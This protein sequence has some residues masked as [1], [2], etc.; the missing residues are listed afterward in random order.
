MTMDRQEHR[1]IL[2]PGYA[3]GVTEAMIEDLV[4]AFYAKVRADAVL[5]PIF[6]G[7][8]GDHWDEHLSKLCDFWSS[9]LLASGRYSGAPMQVHAAL[10]QIQAEHFGQ[11]L[12]LFKTTAAELWPKPAAE[13]VCARA[14]MIAKSF[15]YGIAASRGDLIDSRRQAR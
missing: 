8:I 5:G 7:V 3:V 10:P 13:L 11:W 14:D 2:S 6:D 12:A 1:R 15:Q 4:H 9:V